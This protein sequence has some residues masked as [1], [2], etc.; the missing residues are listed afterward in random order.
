MN[1]ALFE[2]IIKKWRK[3]SDPTER[4]TL[5]QIANMVLLKGSSKNASTI[6]ATLSLFIQYFDPP[7]GPYGHK[8]GVNWT[9]VRRDHPHLMEQQPPPGRPHTPPGPATAGHPLLN[10]MKLALT[11]E[12]AA[13]Q[14]ELDEH[15]LNAWVQHELGMAGDGSFL[16]EC[17]VELQRDTELPIPEGVGVLLKFPTFIDP[18]LIEATLLSYDTLN[19]LV[20]L[21]VNRPL[22]LKHVN[23]QFVVIPR[24]E[25]LLIA[26]RTRLSELESAKSALSWRLLR[27][28][29]FAAKPQSWNNFVSKAGLDDAQYGAIQ[30]CLDHDITFLWGPPGTGKTHTLAYLIAHAALGGKKV[31]ATA[32]AN[33]AVDQLAMKTVK[34]LE[35]SDCGGSALLDNGRI[36]RFGHARLHEVTREG[37]LFPNKLEIQRLRK[38]LHEAQLKLKEIPQNRTMD[39]ALAQKR[40][41]DLTRDL[42]KVTKE[43]IESSRVVITTAIQTCIES[44]FSETKFDMMVV[45]EASMMS[46]PY[47][48]CMGLIARERLIIAGDFKQLG[49]IALAQSRAAFDWLHKDAFTLTGITENLSHP[50]LARLTTQRRMR[51]EICE[52]INPLFYGGMLKTELSS[53]N[54]AI[55]LPP[56]PGSPAVFVSLLREDGSEAIKTQSGSRVNQKSAEIVVKLATC[57]AETDDIQIGIITPYRAQVSRIKAFLRDAK[58][59]KTRL[60]RIKIGTVH[61]F[62]GAESDVIV[63]DLVDTDHQPIGR[64]YRDEPGNR[65]TNVAISRARGK[66]V[67]IGDRSVFLEGNGHKLVGALKGILLNKFSERLGNLVS[68][69]ELN[70]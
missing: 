51:P 59:D 46:I 19:S 16:Y 14:R 67:I 40:V 9:S 47:L 42:R 7:K 53:V 17:Y 27:Q 49:P 36:L 34:A 4:L 44:A 32:I 30:K 8:W 21:E 13:V 23:R 57:Y 10:D 29:S 2:N 56:K 60:E 43:T 64:L 1:Q 48:A 54:P 25:E 24:L 52:L 35:N 3:R 6:G 18:P 28:T 68:V 20:I 58:L 70:I 41:S 45:D 26:L 11:N 33:V 63:W 69:H 22:S 55:T 66:L 15:P 38:L 37:R 61:A 65:L 62:Q 50:A 31:I 5:N 12:I 39:R